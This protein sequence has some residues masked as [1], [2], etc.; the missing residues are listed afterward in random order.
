MFQR[1]IVVETAVSNSEDDDAAKKRKINS[2]VACFGLF[3]FIQEIA[4]KIRSS[5]E[6]QEYEMNKFFCAFSLPVLLHLSQLQMWLD[7]IEKFPQISNEIQ[8]DTS[9]KD[10]LKTILSAKL[11]K[12][13]SMVYHQD[14]LMINIHFLI[15]NEVELMN[16]LEE[17]APELYVE[18]NKQK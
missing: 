2:C 11:E 1:N 12:E 5:S 8:P 3:N 4:D 10:V 9:I 17:V 14:G 16:K 15:A 13:L 18:R 6:L 7:L